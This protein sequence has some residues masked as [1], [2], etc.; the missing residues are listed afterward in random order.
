MR[1]SQSLDPMNDDR[2]GRSAGGGNVVP[3]PPASSER[4]KP[5]RESQ[6]GLDWFIFFLADVQTGFGPFIA[7]YLTTQKWTQVEIGFVLSI[8]GIVGLLGQ[9]PGGA[10]V[11][12]ARSERL[13][14]GL[15]V[16][17]IG[18]CALAYAL[19]PI[20]PVVTAAAILH[21]LASCVLGPAI[22][23]ISLGL[24]GPFAIGERLGR[25]ARF[26]S[27]GNGSAAAL[28]GASGYLLSSQ[29]VF[30]VT[31]FL[32]IPT[33][34][35]LARIRGQEINVAQAHGAL[36]EDGDDTKAADKEA[37]SVLH[38]LRQRPLLI[39]AGGVLLFQLANA[40]MLPLMAGVVTTRSA[41]W[42]P[43]L[44]AA[45]IIVPQAI[46]ALTSPSVGRKA[47]AWGR[48]PLLLLAFAALAIRGLLFAVVRDPYVLVLVQV[49]DG[50]TAAVLSVMV[51][52]IVAD[53]AYGSGHFNLAQGIVGTATGIGASLSTVLAGYISDIFG[54][55][56]AFIGLAG[57]AALGLTVIWAFMP[58]TRRTEV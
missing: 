46:V 55:S 52:L 47:Q 21:A 38:L 11:D 36:S 51:P 57:I 22:A 8:G 34:L 39:F 53:V 42:A 30:F 14:A 28:M 48:R 16:A 49:F 17:T 4:P 43:V 29:S 1:P 40:A 27:L 9:M 18:C 50:I 26:A 24:V 54:S 41:Q 35:A 15:A 31:F 12:A 32:A 6:R 20:F 19:W 3:V 44:I 5:S 2:H 25:N 23:A 58:E 7:V 33:L 37:T 45:C 10:V 13:V 56:V